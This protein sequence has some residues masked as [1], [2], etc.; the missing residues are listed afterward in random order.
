M[1]KLS[2]TQVGNYVVLASILVSL[3][4]LNITEAELQTVAEAI[5]ALVGVGMAWY[6][7][8]RKGDLTLLG[9]RK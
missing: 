6:G 5:V 9:A 7:R 4:K 2:L 1:E 8:Y 3:L